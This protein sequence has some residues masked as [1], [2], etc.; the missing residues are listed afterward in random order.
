M[1]RI[2][3]PAGLDKD[4]NTRD[5]SKAIVGMGDSR[6]NEAQHEIDHKVINGRKYWRT[7]ALKDYLRR[8]TVTVKAAVDG[9]PRRIHPPSTRKGRRKAKA[10][11]DRAST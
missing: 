4:L 11:A 1:P 2:I 3:K 8:H 7:A 6:W 9:T 5:D 10:E